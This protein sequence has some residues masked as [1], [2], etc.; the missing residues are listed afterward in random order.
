[1]WELGRSDESL[2]ILS[3]MVPPEGPDAGDYDA[4]M[5]E[6]LRARFLSELEPVAAGKSLERA[7]E[8]MSYLGIRS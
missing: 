8:I 5:T 4:A 1:M 2:Q 6:L 3:A 7:N